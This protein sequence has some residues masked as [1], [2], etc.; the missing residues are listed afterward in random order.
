[1]VAWSLQRSTLNSDNMNERRARTGFVTCAILSEVNEDALSRVSEARV[2][3]HSTCTWTGPLLASGP[4]G[5][6]VTYSQSD[7]VNR[8]HIRD[9]LARVLI[10]YL[11]ILVP[12]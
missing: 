7:L 9:Q 3:R 10:G 5:C 1:M 11:R 2:K 6:R 4:T 8:N 12:L